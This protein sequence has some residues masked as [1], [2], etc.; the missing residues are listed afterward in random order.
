MLLLFS[1]PNVHATCSLY[2]TGDVLLSYLL[3]SSLLSL[4]HLTFSPPLPFF[5]L[6]FWYRVLLC[7]QA[8][9]QWHDLGSLQPLPP[10]LKQFSCLSLLSSWDYRRKPPCPAN[11]CIFFVEMGFHHVGYDGL[12]ILTSWSVH[13]GLPKCW[14]YRNEPPRPANSATFYTK[15]WLK[16]FSS[17]YWF[18]VSN[19]PQKL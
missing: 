11:F 14:D 17:F 9:V 18:I 1:V 15:L 8:G 19:F 10:G 7:H 3:C 5:C 16:I 13:L 6:F 2:C 4:V 12:H